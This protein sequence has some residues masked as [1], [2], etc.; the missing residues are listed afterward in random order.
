MIRFRPDS[1]CKRWFR[2]AVDVRP[3]GQH[4]TRFRPQTETLE[5]RCLLAAPVLTTLTLTPNPASA[6]GMVTLDGAFTDADAGQVYRV[7]VDWGDGTPIQTV[8]LGAAMTFSIP[9]TFPT[10]NTFNVNVQVRDSGLLYGID[11]FSN[12]FLQIDPATAAVVS[13]VPMTLAGSTVTGGNS[14]TTHPLTGQLWAIIKVAGQVGRQL[15]TIDPATGVAT[16]I[17]NT[18]R[19][20]SSLSF[21]ANGTLYGVTGNGDANPE[22]MFILNQTD[23]T[24]T[25]FLALGNGADGEVIAYNPVDGL[26]YHTSGNGTVIFETINLTTFAITNIPFGAP[27][28]TGENFGLVWSEAQGLF[29][30]SDISGDLFTATPAAALGSA[31]LRRRGRCGRRPPGERLQ[32]RHWRTHHEFLCLR[33]DLYRRRPRG[34]RR[35]DGR[36]HPGRHHRRG[37][38]RRAAGARL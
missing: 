9:H 20:F 6:N 22:V 36:W 31:H 3:L 1:W 24:S 33:P 11:P 18:G 5:T 19:N 32:R 25:V 15:V 4:P 16:S 28:N 12:Q 26:M 27:L 17:G 2:P 37:A 23:A 38:G 35:R 29:L 21:D 34:R 8:N 30:W 7:T 13:S 14:V 10:P